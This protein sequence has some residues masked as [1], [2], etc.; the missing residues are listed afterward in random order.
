MYTNL[1]EK[2]KIENNERI[3][4]NDFFEGNY[5]KGSFSSNACTD[6]FDVK[7]FYA[8]FKEI[9]KKEN[10]KEVYRKC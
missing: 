6:E 5:V 1:T 2:G 4:V 7:E 3:S 8:I 9:E 10:V